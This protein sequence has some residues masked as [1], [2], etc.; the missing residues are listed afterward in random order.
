VTL[1]IVVVTHIILAYD[2]LTLRDGYYGGRHLSRE[3]LGYHPRSRRNSVSFVTHP[4]AIDGYR[5]AVGY[6]IE[7]RKAGYHMPG[8]SLAEAQSNILLAS[9]EVYYL[10]DMHPDRH[11]HIYLQV[12]V[13]HPRLQLLLPHTE[14]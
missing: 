2:D 9:D 3:S 14:S 12:K 7:F 1:F 13:C 10:D 8:I 4:P 6:L 5:R 11:E